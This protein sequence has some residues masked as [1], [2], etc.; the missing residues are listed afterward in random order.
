MGGPSVPFQRLKAEAE[1]IY[2]LHDDGPYRGGKSLKAIGKELGHSYWWAWRR[3]HWYLDMRE[4]HAGFMVRA[5]RLPMRGSRNWDEADFERR[6]AQ[7][8]K[9]RATVKAHE[10][11]KDAEQAR[12]DAAAATRNAEKAKRDEAKQWIEAGSSSD[13][14]PAWLIEALKITGRKSYRPGTPG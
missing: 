10:A 14:M 1:A 8:E 5:N 13:R 9:I 11:L 7:R 2:R 12:V 3:Y 6:V 4:A